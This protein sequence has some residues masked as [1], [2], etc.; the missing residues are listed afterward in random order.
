[1]GKE[2]FRESIEKIKKDD[3]QTR[4]KKTKILLENKPETVEERAK[5]MR[6]QMWTKRPI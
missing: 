4:S 3:L 1:M 2:T 5:W 6:K